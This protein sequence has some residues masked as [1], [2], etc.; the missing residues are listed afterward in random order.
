MLTGCC[1]DW[2]L[3]VGQAKEA[4][5]HPY[6]ADLDKATVDLLENPEL[7]VPGPDDE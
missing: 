7:R 3:C 1:A 2:L 6:F 5:N 4:I